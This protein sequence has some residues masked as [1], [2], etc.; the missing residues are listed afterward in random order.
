M[1]INNTKRRNGIIAAALGAALLMGGGTFALWSD[2][3]TVSGGAIHTGDL[4]ITGTAGEIYDLSGED[5]T[6]AT[7][8]TIIG[9]VTDESTDPVDGTFLASPGD[10]LAVAFTY[11][12]TLKGDNLRADLVLDLSSLEAA[13]TFT[14]DYW[15]FSYAIYSDKGEG[16]TGTGPLALDDSNKWEDL[17]DASDGATV[18]FVLLVTFLPYPEGVDVPDVY[19][20]G[21]LVDLAGDVTMTLTQVRDV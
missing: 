3:A 17:S 19:D 5:L 2:S 21:V 4:A 13:G 16:V 14:D 20:P 11:G 1:R 7:A 15:D 6:S 8:A 9:L 10:V 18:T 12:I